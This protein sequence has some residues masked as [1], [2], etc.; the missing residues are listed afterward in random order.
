MTDTYLDRHQ[1]HE[2]YLQRL[3]SELLNKYAY[4]NLTQA[5]KAARLIVLDVDN[6]S[7]NSIKRRINS[8]IL[9]SENWAALT[10]ELTD[11]AIYEAAF[12]ASMFAE[13]NDLPIPMRVPTDTAISRSVKSDVMVF[14]SS[15]RT[16]AG[17]WGELVA[18]NL[19][20]VAATFNNQIR[21]ANALGETANQAVTRMR[22]IT[23]GALMRD[24][25]NLVR[26]GMAQHAINSRELLME[27]NNDIVK[28]KFFNATFDNRTTKQCMSASSSASNP[29]LLDDESAPKLP[30]HYNERSNYL[31]LIEGQ[32]E[33]EGTKTAVGGKDTEEAREAFD[34]RQ[35]RLNKRRDNPAIDGKT[36]SQVRYR[37]RRDQDI[38]DV[39][40][41]TE[42]KSSTWLRK[43][44][45]YFVNDTLG[46]QRAALFL[47]EG[48]ALTKFTDMT[49][50]PLT[51][52]QIRANGA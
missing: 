13:V 51:L 10:K 31:Y 35:A 21:A 25:E 49:F 44:P 11:T 3:A 50:R 38:F 9:Q 27:E 46:P 4:P 7:D 12:Y 19:A 47:D 23:Q 30:L 42:S 28:R 16:L 2:I 45:R 20:S 17:T 33:P 41:V 40:Q 32:T 14:E 18:L 1:R 34:K 43:Q 37:G 15:A 26:T 22:N 29:W 36:S 48:F 52:A 24:A 5:Y 6:L 8:A 39:N